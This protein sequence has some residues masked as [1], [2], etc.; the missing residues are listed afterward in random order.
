MLQLHAH[1][2]F[3]EV[4]FTFLQDA[5]VSYEQYKLQLVCQKT[6]VF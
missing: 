3:A 6:L 2:T 4:V 1:M 5:Y